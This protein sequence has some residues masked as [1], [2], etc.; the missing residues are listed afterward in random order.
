MPL[1][2]ELGD[3]ADGVAIVQYLKNEDP[4]LLCTASNKGLFFAD[5]Q[6]KIIKHLY[7]GHNQNPAIA[8]FR[9]D[10]PGF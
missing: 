9:D 10:L 2:N 1:K 3:Y 5:L 7:I 4:V 6:D 8:N